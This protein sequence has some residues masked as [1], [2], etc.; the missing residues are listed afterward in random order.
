MDFKW[1]SHGP[2]RCPGGLS[3][4]LSQDR[5]NQVGEG[6][7]FPSPKKGRVL[8]R[9][10]CLTGT[11]FSTRL[12]PPILVISVK[13]VVIAQIT[14]ST[15]LAGGVSQKPSYPVLNHP[16][17]RCRLY[18]PN[19]FLICPS[20]VAQLSLP[21]SRSPFLLTCRSELN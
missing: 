14:Q 21:C 11:H 10:M 2:F 18:H 19:S 16:H 8:S 15:N 12:A 9:K 5:S 7:L 4:G 17:K 13:C 20:S 3:A 6:R 1:R